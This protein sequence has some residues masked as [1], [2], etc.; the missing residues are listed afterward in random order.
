MCSLWKKMRQNNDVTDRTCEIY[1]K[2]KKKKKQK[3]KLSWLILHGVV[4]DEDKT[5]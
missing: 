3:T 5:K 1:A 2:T 4:Y